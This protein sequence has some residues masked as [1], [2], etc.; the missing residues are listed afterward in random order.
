MCPN[1]GALIRL[2]AGKARKSKQSFMGFVGGGG[3]EPSNTFIE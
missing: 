3:S 1:Q 2:Y